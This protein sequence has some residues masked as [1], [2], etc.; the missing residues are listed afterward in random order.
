MSFIFFAYYDLFAVKNLIDKF[1]WKYCGVSQIW[2]QIK[3]MSMC[4][5]R[6]KLKI[7]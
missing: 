7:T 3:S 6:E 2:I 4:R 1:V 5:T